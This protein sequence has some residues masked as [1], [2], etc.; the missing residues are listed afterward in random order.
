[1]PIRVQNNL[2][3]QTVEQHFIGIDDDWQ[4]GKEAVK[5]AFEGNGLLL[6]TSAKIVFLV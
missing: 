2:R 1:V 4:Q 3:V 5:D 6:S